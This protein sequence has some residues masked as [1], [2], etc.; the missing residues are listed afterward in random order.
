MF[1]A[2]EDKFWLRFCESLDRMDLY[3]PGRQ[4]PGEDLDAEARLREDLTAIFKSRTRREWTDFF[5]ATDIA[6]AQH[7]WETCWRVDDTTV[8]TSQGLPNAGRSWASVC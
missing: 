1:N 6:G 8:T 4:K 3:E 5:I 7:F 2:L